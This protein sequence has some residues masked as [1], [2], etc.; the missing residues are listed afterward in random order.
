MVSDAFGG[1]GTS[2]LAIHMQNAVGVSQMLLP[3]CPMDRHL[4]TRHS[5]WTVKHDIDM[6]THQE[7]DIGP[8]NLA[9]ITI[10]ERSRCRRHY[11][12]TIKQI[13]SPAYS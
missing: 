7:E 11:F 8:L 2:S 3:A 12:L 4:G 9:D 5:Q 13:F 1:G 10:A 6:Q